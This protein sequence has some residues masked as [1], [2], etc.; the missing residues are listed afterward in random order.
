MA[1]SRPLKP[2]D[3][4]DIATD[5]GREF[6]AIIDAFGAGAL[7]N[8]VPK[9]IQALEQLE[10]LSLQ[11]E[12]ESASLHEL[13]KTV[14]RLEAEKAER[15][16]ERQRFEKELEE[17]EERT[18]EETQKL[19]SMVTELQTEN[20]RMLERR[21]AERNGDASG[22]TGTD[23]AEGEIDMKVL[24]NLKAVIDRQRD[25]LTAKDAQLHERNSEIEKFQAD[26]DRMKKQVREQRRR[27]R[28]ASGQQRQLNEE[29][30]LLEAELTDVRRQMVALRQQLGTAQKENQ[31]LSLSADSSLQN[32]V[33]YDRDD[34]ARPRFTF[35][36]LRDILNERNELKAR[37]SDLQDELALYRPGGI[38][39]SKSSI[40]CPPSDEL[41]SFS[42][43]DLS[44][45]PSLQ[46]E[47][48]QQKTVEEDLPVHGPLPQDPEDAPWK[49][50]SSESG[51]RRLFRRLFYT[52]GR[53]D[54]P[55][56]TSTPVKPQTPGGTTRR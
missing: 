26:L 49:K 17:F 53:T 18:R 33:V 30:T 34:P 38:D 29:R 35:N 22:Q 39:T 11:R 13:R 20:R 37:L 3:V 27:Q 24:F 40:L 44:S 55:R 42:S 12:Q 41:D 15:A 54:S 31:D 32:K 48:E 51:I 10:R 21:E 23:E 5:I 8:L 2:V 14:E 36:E 52:D 6:E 28:A 25:D 16:A 50:S 1:T 46:N 56:A 19:V 43:S 45:P 9:V 7:T 47:L 4:Y